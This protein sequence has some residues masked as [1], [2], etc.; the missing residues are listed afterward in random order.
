M[1]QIAK[2][3]AVFLLLTLPITAFGNEPNGENIALNRPVEIAQGRKYGATQ[4]K[5]DPIQ[6]TDGKPAPAGGFWMTKETV[7]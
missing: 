7:G 1:K 2:S 5:N 6:I 3:L 4:D